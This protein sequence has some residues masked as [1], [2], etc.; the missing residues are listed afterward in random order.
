MVAGD[1][2]AGYDGGILAKRKREKGV[3]GKR[4]LNRDLED[5]M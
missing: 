4:Y 3:E 1:K 2:L 5:R